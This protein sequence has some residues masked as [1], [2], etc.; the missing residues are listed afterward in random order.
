MSGDCNGL[1]VYLHLHSVVWGVYN[2]L[3]LQEVI[4]INI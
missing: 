1:G 3:Y 4:N 2:A